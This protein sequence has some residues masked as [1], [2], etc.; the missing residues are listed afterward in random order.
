[1]LALKMNDAAVRALGVLDGLAAVAPPGGLAPG[2]RDLAAPGIVRRGRVLT[3]PHS[4]RDADGAPGP[5]QDLTGWE[6]SD[7]SIH[8]DDRVSVQ[9][10]VVDG[11]PVISEADELARVVWFLTTLLLIRMANTP[12]SS[13]RSA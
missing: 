9:I 3:W 8:L 10:A 7:S 2:L 5:F 12:C 6:C 4:A 1:M 13:D 11:E